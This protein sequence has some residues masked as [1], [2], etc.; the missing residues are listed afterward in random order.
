MFLS[1][2]WLSIQQ[3]SSKEVSDA[4]VVVETEIYK[5]IFQ[6]YLHLCVLLFRVIALSV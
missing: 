3:E 1:I 2:L 4:P 6:L 5:S